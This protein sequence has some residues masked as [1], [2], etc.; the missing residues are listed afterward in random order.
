M[1]TDAAGRTPDCPE[2]LNDVLDPARYAAMKR[3]AMLDDLHRALAAQHADAEQ[4][5]RK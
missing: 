4:L 3:E 2:D 5:R 1:M